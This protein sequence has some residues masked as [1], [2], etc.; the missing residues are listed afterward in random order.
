M[1]VLFEK[2]E[3]NGIR[4]AN[5][6]VR[7]ATW[8]GLADE[9]GLVQKPMI[10]ALAAL[11]EGGTGLIISGH[12]YVTR[13]GQAGPRQLGAYDDSCSEGLA[14]LVEGVHKAGGK[15]LLQAA[16]AGI[17]AWK[18]GTGLEAYGPTGEVFGYKGQ[19][20]DE[21]K[22]QETVTAFVRA[23]VQAKETGFDGVQLHSAHGYL[24][25]QFLSPA[26]NKRDDKYGG[27]L[28]NRARFTLAMTKAVREAVGPD[29]PVMMKINCADFLDG[30]LTVDDS[31]Q[32][33]KWLEG[34]GL[35]A[36]EVSGGTGDSGKLMPSRPGIKPGRNEGYFQE[37]GK[38]FKEALSI[39]VILVGG[40]RTPEAAEELIADG[41]ADY[42]ALC[43]PL[44]MEPGLVGRWQ[45]GDRSPA[46]CISDNRCFVPIRNNEGF[47]CPHN[48]KKG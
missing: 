38:R 43:R 32:V 2:T 22:I 5:R 9:N 13:E 25:S 33:A 40:V 15:V 26:Y 39:P 7:S 34:A 45:A 35:D 30:G 24:S 31:V 36:I 16:H 28:E 23:A 20:M 17:R 47:F 1:S 27:S 4:L 6:F 11:A 18:E 42:I 41:A 46:T 44:I 48:K 29:Y 8:D 3:I 12:A 19:A 21:E 37:A 10:E 14:A